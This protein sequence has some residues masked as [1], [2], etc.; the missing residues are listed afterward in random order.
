MKLFM[1]I[2]TKW[3]RIKSKTTKKRINT[4][5]GMTGPYIAKVKHC[6]NWRWG[7]ELHVIPEQS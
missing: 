1:K 2:P 4:R 6:H 3:N 5:L 7:K